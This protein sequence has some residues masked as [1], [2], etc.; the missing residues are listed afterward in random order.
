MTEL[1]LSEIEQ[2][3][4]RSQLGV[5]PWVKPSDVLDLVYEIRRL[6]HEQE[7]LVYRLVKADIQR[8]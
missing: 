6:Q 5:D 2:Q 4:R 1:E 8:P 7:R 3:A